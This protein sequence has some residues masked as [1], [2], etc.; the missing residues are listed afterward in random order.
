MGDEN[1]F[2]PQKHKPVLEK[3]YIWNC[4]G[5]NC[6]VC[7]S[8]EGRVFTYDTWFSAGVLPGFHLNCN[9]TLKEVS[10]LHPLSDP[11]I[12]GTDLVLISEGIFGWMLR[13]GQNFLRVPYNLRYTRELTEISRTQSLSIPEASKS[14]WGKLRGYS[15]YFF[16]SGASSFK[17]FN[18]PKIPDRLFPY[19]P[20]LNF[21]QFD[22]SFTSRQGLALKIK[23]LKAKPPISRYSSY[24]RKYRYNR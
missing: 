23:K 5:E 3:K 11:D 10:I 8:L 20:T 13:L 12:F 19:S 14:L 9:C 17:F 7:D 4:W 22:G 15:D 6:P 24:Y 16:G 1:P 2:G 18:Y 21:K